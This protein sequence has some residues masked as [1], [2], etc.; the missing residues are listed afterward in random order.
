MKETARH[1]SGKYALFY[2]ERV[3]ERSATD[4][5]AAR[6]GLLNEIVN[7]LLGGCFVEWLEDFG[8]VL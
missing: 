2:E 4:Q 5:Y 1:A 7:F 6:G 3:A 8:L